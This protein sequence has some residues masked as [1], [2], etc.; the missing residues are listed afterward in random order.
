MVDPEK[1]R[2]A[3]D[4]VAR[5]VLADAARTALESGRVGW[6]DYPELDERDW[7]AVTERARKL[8]ATLQH[9]E[10]MYAEAYRYLAAQAEPDGHVTRPDPGDF[11]DRFIYAVQLV[12]SRQF[13]AKSMV[14][15]KLGTGWNET[16]RLFELL[17]GWGV[18]APTVGSMAHKVLMSEADG[19][20]LVAEL[21]K[22]ERA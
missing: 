8:A 22:G 6:E 15:R 21:Q 19:R 14:A 2:A 16:V 12:T 4:T 20:A 13:G 11:R 7:I 18:V 5:R 3:V 17:E 9:S 1:T 10:A